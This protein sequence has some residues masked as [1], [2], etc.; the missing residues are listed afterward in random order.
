MLIIGLLLV[1]LSAAAVTLLIAYNSSG[2]TEQT[3]VLFGRDWINVNTLEAFLAGIGFALLFSIGVWM[4]VATERRRRTVRSEYRSVR[5]EARI[6]AKERDRTARERDD[7]ARQ[8]EEERAA[9][10]T[11]TTTTAAPEREP[12]AGRHAADTTDHPVTTDRTAAREEVAEQPRRG[13][14]RYFRRSHRTEETPAD[15]PTGGK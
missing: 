3:I 13:L 8:L 12:V 2:G 15:H 6:A 14:G 10:A 7:L 1:V 9:T 4:I 11:T 5:R